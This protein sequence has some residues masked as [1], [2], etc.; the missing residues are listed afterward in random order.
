M[1]QYTGP[2]RISRNTCYIPFGPLRMA[3]FRAP[4][5]QGADTLPLDLIWPNNGDTP[6]REDRRG[7]E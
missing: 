7:P 6:N 4:F 5:I 3:S 1:T 2:Y